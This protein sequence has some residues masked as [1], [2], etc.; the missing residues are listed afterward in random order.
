MYTLCNLDCNGEKYTL[1]D[2]TF[3]VIIDLDWFFTVVSGTATEKKNLCYFLFWGCL[4]SL[5]FKDTISLHN[6]G[7]LQDQSVQQV[8]HKLTC[9]CLPS[10]GFKTCTTIIQLSVKVLNFSEDQLFLLEWIFL[11]WN[12]EL[13][14][15]L[16]IHILQFS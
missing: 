4:F 7:C 3:W 10:S 12:L 2:I 14:T 5:F 16:I 11:P 8:Y 15:L 1:G 9:L 13:L 6:P